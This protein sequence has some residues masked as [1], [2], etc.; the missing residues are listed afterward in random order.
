MF[1][2]HREIWCQVAAIT[3]PHYLN[4]LKYKILLNR[5]GGAGGW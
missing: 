4:T 5:M 1:P 2:Y 3:E